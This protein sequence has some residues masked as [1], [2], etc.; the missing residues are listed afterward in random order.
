MIRFIKT[1]P[2]KRYNNEQRNEKRMQR[3]FRS[4]RK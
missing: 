2:H 4:D 1:G 3:L